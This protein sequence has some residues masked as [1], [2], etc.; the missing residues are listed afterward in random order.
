M[1]E[2][3]EPTDKPQEGTSPPGAS[4]PL[5]VHRHGWVPSLVWLVPIVAAITG[6]VL[7]VQLW[8]AH[9]P[10]VTISFKSAEGLAAGQ[11][12]V[13]YKN[14]DIGVV[15]S[16]G[17]SEDL[18]HVRV[19]VE[20]NK[21][22]ERFTAA[23]TRFWVV[24]ARVSEGGVTGLAT[25]LSGSYLG[26]DAGK[27]K[28]KADEF[29]GLETPPAITAD[30]RGREFVLHASDRG[31]LDIGSPV[32]YRRIPAGQ[33][34]AY[35]L[36][37][38]GR[39]VTIQIFVKEPYDRYITADSRFWQASGVSVT[40]D[41]NGMRINTQS[42]VSLVLGG[43]AFQSP[44]DSPLTTPA[45]DNTVF[46]LA[47]DEDTAMRSSQGEAKWLELFFDQSLR[48]LAPGAQV[49]FRGVLLGE[50]KSVSAEYDPVRHK[51]TMPVLVEVFPARLGNYFRLGEGHSEQ[52]YRRQLNALVQQGLRAQL[53]SGNLLTGKLYVAL[54]FFPQAKP[55][56][57]DWSGP[58]PALPTLRNPVDQLPNQLA[59]IAAKL[60]KV[61]FEQIGKNLNGT[62]ARA[63]SL[64]T[65]LDSQ[66]APQAR[67]TLDEARKSFGALQ[68][69]L[70]ADAP[71]Q[72]D[73]RSAM[74]QVRR[75]AESLRNLSDY[76]GRHPEALLRGKPGDQP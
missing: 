52:G 28:Q 33:V 56:A 18:S 42:V 75:A 7:V 20:L 3:R 72:Q 70:S 8:L 40:L 30:Q 38:D 12:R 25:I 66:V 36:D 54:D 63:N 76:L 9:G 34:V 58:I 17:L 19:R 11:T 26:V 62:L 37:S 59:E 29:V 48:G 53:R 5:V 61:P 49:D 32:Y 2:P 68:Q 44:P 50:V 6:L 60:D 57:V 1:T 22:A 10:T 69:L 43:I 74:Q 15:K 13:K 73:A 64:L 31:S 39:G 67:A 46:T 16:I 51:L 47:R 4:E 14:V 45:P 35:K 27:S 24:R 23:D 41:A 55:A 71:V 65:Q 21:D